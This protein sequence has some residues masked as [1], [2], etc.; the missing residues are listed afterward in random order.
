VRRQGDFVILPPTRTAAFEAFV[1]PAR[2]RPALWRL[3]LGLAVIGVV[4]AAV[5][6]ALLPLLPRLPPAVVGR[7]L[8]VL[9]LFG[10]AGM[11]LG[12]WLALRL[13][14]RRSFASLFGP[15][16]FEPRP[17]GIGVAVIV[18]VGAVSALPALVLAPP[19]RQAGFAAWAAWLPLALPAL[20][21]QT[22]AEELVF[23]GY[24]LQ[25]LAVR[26]RSAF[27]WWLVPSVL[28]GALHWNPADFGPNA[29]L[30]VVAATDTGLVLADVTVR[31]GGLSA[32][33]GLH[34]AN[35]VSALLILAT[36]SEV[37]A[38][39]LFVLGV[40]PADPGAMRRLLIAD[41]AMTLLA[42]GVWLAAWSRWRRLH[43]KGRG[44][45]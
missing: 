16:G 23:R 9:Y 8:L 30:A 45:I 25:G 43:S 44:S 4:W 35:N 20:L 26:F 38:L 28:F 12:L 10:F 18:A 13:L 21:V 36:P 24:L 22:A 41:M 15:A 3:V 31:T 34:F 29:W 40:D 32:A 17:F 27:G 39:S 19:F 14:Q 11:V 2:A 5:N 37:A 1:A 42:Y 33:I 6:L 7:A